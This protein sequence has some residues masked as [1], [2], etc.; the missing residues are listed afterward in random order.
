[1]KTENLLRV[2]LRSAR[3]SALSVVGRFP[4]GGRNI[5]AVHPPCP[6]GVNIDRLSRLVIGGWRGVPGAFVVHS[7][8]VFLLI[9]DDYVHYLT[10]VTLINEET[11]A[12]ILRI[13]E[14]PLYPRMWGASMPSTATRRRY[15]TASSGSRGGEAAR[16]LPHRVHHRVPGRQHR[17][18]IRPRRRRRM[19]ILGVP[20]RCRIRQ[21]GRRSR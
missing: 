2:S 16:H 10:E 18:L 9:V 5:T 4:L 11:V 8:F 12:S 1:V 3:G 6:Q 14:K 19:R 7:P 20:A 13:S 17:S 21:A 15:L